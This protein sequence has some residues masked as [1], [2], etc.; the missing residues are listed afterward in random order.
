[1]EKS[2]T[3]STPLLGF[4]SVTNPDKWMSLVNKL[5]EISLIYSSES[6]SD[7]ESYSRNNKWECFEESDT[8]KYNSAEIACI[9]SI[10]FSYGFVMTTMLLVILPLEVI[11]MEIGWVM[12]K[13]NE[14]NDNS[15]V[16]LGIFIFASGLMQLLCPI[17]GLLSDSCIPLHPWGKRR[18]FLISS[19]ILVNFSL[20][21][22]IVCSLMSY[23]YLYF[24]FFLN[25]MI[26]IN[27]CYSLTIALIPDLI[28]DSQVGKANAILAL[29]VTTGSLIG[30]LTFHICDNTVLMYIFYIFIS[31]ITVTITCFMAHEETLC[32]LRNENGMT[33]TCT[34]YYL[35]SFIRVIK[36]SFT[37]SFEFETIVNS[38]SISAKDHGDFFYCTVSRTFYYMGISVQTFLLYFI[39]D[40]IFY[41]EKNSSTEDDTITFLSS[42]SSP[43]IIVSTLAILMQLAGLIT[44]Y[45]IGL[46]SDYLQRRKVFI[47]ISCTILSLGCISL[48]SFAKTLSTIIYVVIFLG[49]GNGMYLTIETSL[50]VD[51]LPKALEG[52]IGALDEQLS[53]QDKK[54][55]KQNNLQ[56][57]FQNIEQS[58]SSSKLKPAA[59]QLLGIWGVASFV[60]TALGPFVGGPILYFFGQWDKIDLLFLFHNHELFVRGESLSD[61][62]EFRYYA[63]LG[64]MVL[65]GL[66]AF[67]FLM[68]AIVLRY[69]KGAR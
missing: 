65:F 3:V 6:G 12:T 60:G 43:E 30:F 18:P 28:S 51:S 56:S 20:F 54:I 10:A 38:Y 53:Y 52:G 42:S 45:P 7:N 41:E 46:L 40:N 37:S 26:G 58:S 11:R 1:M 68:S 27:V 61:R 57:N 35:T 59:A 13:S 15:S 29:E 21:F 48:A 5:P 33:T 8:L 2:V 31:T 34:Q 49:I 36:S 66:S 16:L 63:K 47:Y 24:I 22:M 14:N 23:W 62:D 39:H 17:I 67:H 50:A 55:T 19:A 25:L 9:L 32:D 4:T 64:Y 69:V 44:C